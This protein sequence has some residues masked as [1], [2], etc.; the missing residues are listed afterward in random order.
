MLF[1]LRKRQKK[2]RALPQILLG[3]V[4]AFFSVLGAFFLL[5]QWGLSALLCLGRAVRKTLKRRQASPHLCVRKLFDKRD[6]IFVILL[7]P[8]LWVRLPAEDK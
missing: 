6:V 8:G 3:P 1:R 5:V 7:H 2:K 4:E